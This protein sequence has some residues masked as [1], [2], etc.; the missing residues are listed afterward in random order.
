MFLSTITLTFTLIDNT[1]V[2]QQ[3]NP[4]AWIPMRKFEGKPITDLTIAA[5]SK[6]GLST[7]FFLPDN[8]E[9]L[10]AHTAMELDHNECV[11]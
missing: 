7:A 3:I 8:Q 4:D 9:V 11:N 2:H 10:D 5:A 6:W 1:L